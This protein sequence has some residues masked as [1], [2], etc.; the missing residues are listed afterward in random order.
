MLAQL[1]QVDIIAD[2]IDLFTKRRLSRTEVVSCLGRPA[3]PTAPG[4]DP[5]IGDLADK[6]SRQISLQISRHG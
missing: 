4:F 1:S 2:R 6:I 5:N 3:I